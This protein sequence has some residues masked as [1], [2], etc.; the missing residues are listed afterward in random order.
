MSAADGFR[1][2]GR[3]IRRWPGIHQFLLARSAAAAAAGAAV[4]ATWES[5]E[6]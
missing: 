2:N 6:N 4:A 3:A 1:G 5:G